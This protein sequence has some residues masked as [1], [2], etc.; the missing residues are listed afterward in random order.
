[1]EAVHAVVAIALGRGRAI[2]SIEALIALCGPIA[3]QKLCQYNVDQQQ[4]LWKREWSG[5]HA[6]AHRHLETLGGGLDEAWIQA[7]QLV[8]T[9]W[10]RIELVARALQREGTLTGD[11]VELLYRQALDDSG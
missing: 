9:H 8:T 10:H 4:Q 6:N 3:E 5:D 1:M 11:E 7:Q 2:A